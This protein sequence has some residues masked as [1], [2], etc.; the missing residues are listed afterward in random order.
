M[1]KNNTKPLLVQVYNSGQKIIKNKYIPFS[2][3]LYER[4]DGTEVLYISV[5]KGTEVKIIEE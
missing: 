1:L 3:S 5:P 4:N 2:I